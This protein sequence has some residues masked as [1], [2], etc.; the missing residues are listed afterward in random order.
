MKGKRFF[1]L[2]FIL[3]LAV[4]SIVIY[5]SFIKENEKKTTGVVKYFDIEGGF[6][7]IISDEGKN[8]FPINLSSEYKVDGL[9]IRFNYKE[10]KDYVN[11]YIW[12]IPV[13]IL[14]I[15]KN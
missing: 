1:W 9:K 15:D 3:I 5:S 14:N 10:V 8:Y 6:Y 11:I 13:E 2:I 4:G 12:G 7:G